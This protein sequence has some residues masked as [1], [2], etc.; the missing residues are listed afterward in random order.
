MDNKDTRQQKQHDIFVDVDYRYN[1]HTYKQR[2]LSTNM[3]RRTLRS[4]IAE[5]RLHD[6]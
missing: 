1:V 6:A 5:M 4:K 2:N 3:R